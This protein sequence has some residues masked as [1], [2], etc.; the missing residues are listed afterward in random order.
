MAR[1]DPHS[2]ADLS[3]GRVEHLEWKAALD[4]G[5]RVITAEATLVLAS[6]THGPLDLDTRDLSIEA[7]TT[8]DGKPLEH[9]LAKPEPIFGSRLRVELPRGTK[10]FKVRYRT[11]PQASAL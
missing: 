1:L 9:E 8:M 5:A 3:Q 10:S 4:F 2:Y 6:K 11:S 7:V